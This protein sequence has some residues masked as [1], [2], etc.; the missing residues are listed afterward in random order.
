MQIG[1]DRQDQNAVEEILIRAGGNR[2]C[3]QRVLRMSKNVGVLPLV[4]K[5]NKNIS[6]GDQ[7]KSKRFF[8]FFPCF[9]DLVQ[10]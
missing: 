1:D 5:K 10:C 7:K 2:V 9:F 8:F 6:R 4:E 3:R